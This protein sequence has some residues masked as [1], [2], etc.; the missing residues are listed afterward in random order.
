MV[1]RKRKT[2]GGARLGIDWS[3]MKLGKWVEYK[4]GTEAGV[5]NNISRANKVYGGRLYRWER[6]GKELWVGRER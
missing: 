6:R 1:I 3:G 4:G 2:G 5:K